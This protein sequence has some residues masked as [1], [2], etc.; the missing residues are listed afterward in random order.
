[1]SEIIFRLQLHKSSDIPDPDPVYQNNEDPC[2][3]GSVTLLLAI[4]LTKN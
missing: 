2:G 1:M 4:G 3:S